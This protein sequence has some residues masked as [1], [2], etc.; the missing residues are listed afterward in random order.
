[1]LEQRLVAILTQSPGFAGPHVVDGL[2]QLFHDVKPI[3]HVHGRGRLGGDH[4]QVGLPQI[5]ARESERRPNPLAQQAKAFA[6]AV[7][8]ALRPIHN[9][10]LQR[11]SIW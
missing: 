9:S 6:Q 3:Q 4:V 2:A 10:R 5:A 7:F 1:M 11:A 8:R